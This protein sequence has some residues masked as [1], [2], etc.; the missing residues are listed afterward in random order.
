M[1]INAAKGDEDLIIIG[2]QKL[3]QMRISNTFKLKRFMS[4]L[5]EAEKKIS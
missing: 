3:C 1:E 2:K 4:S 5:K